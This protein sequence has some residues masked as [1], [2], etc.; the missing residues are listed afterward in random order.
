MRYSS[1]IGVVG[2]LLAIVDPA[3]AQGT[4]K[5]LELSCSPEFEAYCG[6]W[7]VRKVPDGWAPDDVHLRLGERFVIGRR[8]LHHWLFPRDP[9][10]KEDRWNGRQIR[11]DKVAGESSDCLVGNVRIKSGHE[12]Q[13][14][15]EGNKPHVLI[16][17]PTVHSDDV[18]GA[19]RGLEIGIGDALDDEDPCKIPEAES[20]EGH[21]H[22]G[23]FH[24]ED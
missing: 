9:L 3:Q 17:L 14:P 16:I 7:A 22:A 19:E 5:Q 8:G 23:T 21:R 4:G 15:G 10:Y 13:S 20:P 12:N 24:A 18:I 11:L 1:V 2:I 6:G